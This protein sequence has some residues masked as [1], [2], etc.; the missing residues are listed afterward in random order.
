MAV[1][2]CGMKH[3]STAASRGA[4]AG[5]ERPPAMVGEFEIS[6]CGCMLFGPGTEPHAHCWDF[7]L[8]PERRRQAVRRTQIAAPTETRSS[9]SPALGAAIR[10]VRGY[11][12]SPGSC[13]R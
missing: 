10:R 12:C 3:A 8:R 4:R 7:Q 9:G 6:S 1:A 11:V 2:G 13:G 5:R